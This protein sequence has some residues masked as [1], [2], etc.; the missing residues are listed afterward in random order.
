MREIILIMTSVDEEEAAQGMAQALVE[1]KLAACVQISPAGVSIYE[2]DGEV[3]SEEEFYLNI[4]TDTSHE[5]A[6]VKWLEENHPYETPEIV[7][8]N[9]KASRDYH[10]WL[11]Q[12]LK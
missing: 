10:D 4:K 5:D 12:S 9:A 1:Q 6:V 8:L 3:C 7:S 11:S 2:W